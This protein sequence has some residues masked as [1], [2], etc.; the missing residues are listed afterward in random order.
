PLPLVVPPLGL[1]SYISRKLLRS[2]ERIS[3]VE[4]SMT[5]N[6]NGTELLKGV[7]TNT[8]LVPTGPRL[9]PALIRTAS[10]STDLGLY[11][12]PLITTTEAVPKFWPNTHSFFTPFTFIPVITGDCE[13]PPPA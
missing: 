11:G 7:I 5:Q 10:F 12:R 9:S 13:P 4:P 6:Q 3:F 2:P 1:L 8:M